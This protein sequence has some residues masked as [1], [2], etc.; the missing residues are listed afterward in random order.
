MSEVNLNLPTVRLFVTVN[1]IVKYL[2][3]IVPHH[4]N[5]LNVFTVVWCVIQWC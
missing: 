4:I 1:I 3:V 5:Q 2:H